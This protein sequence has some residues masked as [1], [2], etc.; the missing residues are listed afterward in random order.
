MS[1]SSSSTA[2][3]GGMSA[4]EM[5]QEHIARETIQ[6]QTALCSLRAIQVGLTASDPERL[7]TALQEAE[8]AATALDVLRQERERFSQKIADL[9]GRDPATVT[10]GRI[11]ESLA[12]PVAVAIREGRQQLRSLALQVERV[13]RAN[14]LVV[15]MR[16]DLIAKIFAALPGAVATG[17]YSP[18]GKLQSPVCGPLWQGR[19]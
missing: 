16:L 7:A 2:I 3:R 19:G 15:W 8:A 6:L 18:A 13:N 17:R 5:C 4:A 12:P 11:V 14:A 1:S 9:L 10:L